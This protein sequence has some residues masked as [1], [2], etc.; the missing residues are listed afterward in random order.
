M[1]RFPFHAVPLKDRFYSLGLQ[2]GSVALS[3]IVFY[4][5]ALHVISS[6]LPEAGGE[7]ASYVGALLLALGLVRPISRY[8]ERLASHK[9][10][11]LHLASVQNTSLHALTPKA[12]SLW[13]HTRSADIMVRIGQDA[14]TLSGR[15]MT[16][17]T[18]LVS[19]VGSA[20]ALLIVSWFSESWHLMLLTGI[21][22]VV[23]FAL[24][25]GL[26][27]A[28][29]KIFNAIHLAEQNQHQGLQEYLGQFA[30]H[31]THHQAQTRKQSLESIAQT[32]ETLDAK[33]HRLDAYTNTL[34]QAILGL[35]MFAYISLQLMQ[36]SLLT[37]SAFIMGL[38]M[39]LAGLEGLSATGFIALSHAQANQAESTLET[40]LSLPNDPAHDTL[41][42]ASDAPQ[43]RLHQLN[44]HYP[45][46]S[47]EVFT[48]PLSQTIPFG[49]K[50]GIEGPSGQ[51]KSTLFKLIQHQLQPSQGR[52][53]IDGINVK[54]LKE[55][56]LRSL[57]FEAE[58]SPFILNAS[59][60]DNLRLTAP[61]A[62]DG[63]LDE[64]LDQL[65]LFPDGQKGEARRRLV[66][67]VSGIELS[68]GERK[69]LELARALLADQPILLLDEPTEGLNPELEDKV[70]TLIWEKAEDKTVLII[71]HK[72]KVLGKC[73]ARL[74]L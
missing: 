17:M 49:T 65:E 8:L 37:S 19:L 47:N 44:A 20:G 3:F 25:V 30:L 24:Y 51:G 28:Y 26:Y 63:Q 74:A 55:A 14:E 45:S 36:P 42:Y 71:S 22:G 31:Q 34:N 50:L 68:M 32:S 21:G 53:E 33:R 12:F 48:T 29:K 58:Q 23:L 56:S 64:V 5:V 54:K 43:L 2:A 52:V 60:A 46:L 6:L 11:F 27:R 67:G 18:P 62:T 15:W 57:I 61:N 59:L 69:R 16:L 72:Q 39:L 38:F 10:T 1:T 70:L 41:R 73:E 7:K 9:V 4:W 66:L 13:F 40:L 35:G